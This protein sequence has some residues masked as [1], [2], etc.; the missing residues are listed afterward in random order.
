MTPLARAFAGF[1]LLNLGALI[2]VCVAY[3]WQHWL[4]PVRD[5]RETRQQRFERLLA[6]LTPHSVRRIPERRDTSRDEGSSLLE[7]P[8]P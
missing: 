2:V 8:Y 1:A 6:Q 4:K 3:A 5:E 7:V